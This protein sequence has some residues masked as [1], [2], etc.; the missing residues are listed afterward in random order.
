MAIVRGLKEREDGSLPYWR[1]V[2]RYGVDGCL[3]A[4]LDE[5]LHILRESQ[6]LLQGSPAEIA[7]PVAKLLSD[8]LSIRTASLRADAPAVSADRATV[9]S[10]ARRDACPLRP[11]LR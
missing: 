1:Q 4:V 9:A 11:A 10:T 3:Q 2:L 7:E 5:Y 8:V 6:G